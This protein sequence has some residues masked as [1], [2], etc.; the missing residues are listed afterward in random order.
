MTDSLTR[1]TVDTGASKAT[2][3]YL[4]GHN[5]EHTRAC[6]SGGLSAQ[7]LRNRKFAGRPQRRLGVSAEWFGIGETVY[8]CN[9]R[10]SYVRHYA[11]NGM[12]RRNDQNAQTVQNPVAGQT[13]GIGQGSLYL[14][15]GRNYTVAVV[16]RAASPIRLALSLT[17]AAGRVT[18]DRKEAEIPA[19]GDWTSCEVTL[20]PNADD[21]CAALR[22]TFTEQCAVVFG[23]VSMLPEDHFHGMRADVGECLRRI[24]VS[25]LRWPGGNFAGEYRWQDMLLPVD[26]RAPLQAYTEDETQ[27]YTHGYDMHEIDTDDFVALCRE[28]GA[29]PFITINLAWDEP[30]QCAAW[31]EYCNGSKDTPYGRLR[32]ERGH[33]EPYNV[34]FWSLGNEMGYGHMEGPMEPSDYARMAGAAA[35]AM[36]EVS[37]DLILCSSGPYG[38]DKTKQWV[39]G[40]AKALMPDSSFV[41]FHTYNGVQHD[42][43]NPD[44]LRCTYDQAMAGVASNLK[45]LRFLRESLPEGIH[46]SYDE[47]NLWAAWFRNSGAMEGIYA[48]KMLHTVLAESLPLDVRIMCYFQPVGEGAIDVLPDHAELTAIGQAFELLKVHKGE[49]QCAIEGTDGYE[50][51]ATVKDG[52]VSVSLIN[53]DYDKPRTFELKGLGKVSG[54]CALAAESILPG[55][56]LVKKTL[57]TAQTE[58]SITVTVPPRA[59]ALLQTSV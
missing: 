14:K 44:G 58:D 59:V 45:T 48:A 28:I 24:G 47:W 17:D 33:E 2:S 55:T 15:A 54:G 53:D 42:Y 39:E 51:Y 52:A 3:P 8:Y 43:T 9:D 57:K 37:P 20:T 40:S 13:V 50:A 30:A 41:S 10:D 16:C 36:L 18:Y 29:E 21:P 12:W 22:L 49:K 46:I 25:I 23:A 31:V 32:A 4:F 1:L 5:L 38:G 19:D 26:Q 6:V 11:K 35:K 7:M 27:P 56:H 34:R